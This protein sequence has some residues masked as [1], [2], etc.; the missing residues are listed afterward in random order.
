MMTCKQALE[1]SGGDMKK[2]VES[3]RKQGS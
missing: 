3:L 1:E 2:A